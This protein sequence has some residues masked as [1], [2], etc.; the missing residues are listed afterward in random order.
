M[1]YKGLDNIFGQWNDSTNIKTDIYALHLDD[2]ATK[3][4]AVCMQGSINQETS[5]AYTKRIAMFK[6]FSPQDFSLSGYGSKEYGVG[7]LDLIKASWE[8]LKSLLDHAITIR[9]SKIKQATT[10]LDLTITKITYFDKIYYF[11]ATQESSEKLYK[12]RRIYSVGERLSSL[13]PNEFYTMS[14]DFDC[15]IDE[16]Q[17]CFFAIKN[18]QVINC[19]NLKDAIKSVVQS[20]DGILDDWT[21]ID[22][23]KDIKDSLDK[24]NVYAPLFR[25]FSDEDYTQQLKAMKAIDFKTRL[26]RVS[27]GKITENDFNGDKLVITRS[28]RALVLDLLSKKLKYNIATDSIEE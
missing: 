15:I 4:V 26:I 14:G 8:V 19:F 21:F 7:N 3:N 20:S 1:T 27:S 18:T 23:V 11:I 2:D 9:E 13:K 10:Y 5:E 16:D 6:T 17:S 28:N 22:N 24:Q 25:I 12:K